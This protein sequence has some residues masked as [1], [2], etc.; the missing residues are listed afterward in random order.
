MGSTA[1][2][3]QPIAFASGPPDLNTSTELARYRWDT[4]QLDEFGWF[5][6][7]SPD[8]RGPLY[9]CKDVTGFL[10]VWPVGCL[11]DI[12]VQDCVVHPGRLRS[13]EQKIAFRKDWDAR[14]Q[15][16]PNA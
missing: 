3:V 15:G 4:V 2:D 1:D 11:C 6:H 9:A 16:G 5:C 10:H 13:K 14:V 8:P 12:G 7:L